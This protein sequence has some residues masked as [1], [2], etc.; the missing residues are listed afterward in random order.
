[1]VKKVI[2]GNTTLLDLTSDTVSA[3]KL[4][5]GYTAH[6]ANGN[7]VIG[8][9]TYDADTS[10]ATATASEILSGE[11]AYVAGS[12]VTG[13]MIDNGAVNGTIS[14]V[15]E[16]YTV[17]EGYHDGTGSVG[18][19]TAE[20]AKIIADNI[21]S[22]VT[23]LGV[24]GTY[25]GSSSADTSDATA[26]ASEVLYGK[27]AYISTGKVTGTMTDN[28][29]VNGTISTVA[30]TYAVPEGYHDGTGYVGIDS[31]EQAKL[32][33]GNIKSGVTLLGV[34]GSYEGSGGTD[35]SDATAVASEV[36]SGKT[37]YISTGKVTGTMTDNGAVSGIISTAFGAYIVPEGYHDGTG[38]VSID[39]AEQAKLIAGNIRDGVT[40]L[41]V[42]GSY[43][44]SG[45]IDTSDATAVAPE[46][47]SGK[48]A[49]ISTGKVTGTMTD[50]GAVSG[51]IS[52]VAGTYSVPEGYHDGTGS[53]SID[54]AEQA[55]IIA[56]NIKAGVT[57]LGV[58]GT[59]GLFTQVTPIA[60]DFA[61][62][63]VSNA[64][65]WT[66][67][68]GSNN[69]A[70]IYQVSKDHTYFCR[71][72]DTVSERWRG[73][74]TTGNPVT[75]TGDLPGSCVVYQNEN[76]VP[77]R[78]CFAYKPRVDGYISIVKTRS[79]V[80]G[81]PTYMYDITGFDLLLGA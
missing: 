11:T 22:G 69:R 51:V 50:N 35:T 58:L 43:E 56:G 6:D 36:L 38:S 5:A 7:P 33:A 67:Q 57:I 52:T 34:T 44:G 49:Y 20:Q 41:G 4:Q 1:M 18:L 53:V 39:S 31:A 12:K 74:F 8:T 63:W 2:Y 65:G 30:G 72:G 70:D 48:T 62:G 42:T 55:K 10:D 16:T 28:G 32:I 27:T 14:T 68:A 78:A 61:D 77:K 26:V 9:S 21:K 25:H 3:D 73:C 47:L 15:A 54:S 59:L 13:I 24:T 64:T 71:L 76:T 17:P 29:A 37:A 45:G 80:T 19:D 40:L 66:Y 60:T 79:G 23:V 75:A 81:I 46:I